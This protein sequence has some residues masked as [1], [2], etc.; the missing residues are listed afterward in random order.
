EQ[1]RDE[2]EQALRRYFPQHPAKLIDFR[3]IK[4]R[5]ATIAQTPATQRRRPFPTTPIDGLWLAGDW[6]ATGL[7]ATLESAAQSGHDAAALA[8]AHRSVE[9]AD[10]GHS[11]PHNDSN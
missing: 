10:A 6:V 9:R 4:E 8:M 3:A 11:P 5:A 7:P 1:L 2:L